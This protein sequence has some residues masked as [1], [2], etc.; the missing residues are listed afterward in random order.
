[1]EIVQPWLNQILG[2]RMVVIDEYEDQPLVLSQCQ[3][4]SEE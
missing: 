2:V 4:K 1:M 3:Y